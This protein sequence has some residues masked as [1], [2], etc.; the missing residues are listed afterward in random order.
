MDRS[1]IANVIR[2]LFTDPS[3]RWWADWAQAFAKDVVDRA[4]ASVNEHRQRNGMG[5]IQLRVGSA[6]SQA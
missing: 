4:L 5:R 1:R 6:R 3:P 2:R